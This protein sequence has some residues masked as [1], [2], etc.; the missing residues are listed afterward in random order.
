[1]LQQLQ[2]AAPIGEKAFTH[3]ERYISSEVRYQ[4]K[5]SVSCS[6]LLP[7]AAQ[8]SSL[9]VFS[10]SQGIFAVCH[11]IAKNSEA[12]KQRVTEVNFMIIERELLQMWCPTFE[13]ETFPY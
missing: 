5:L 13:E 1:M 8:N 2:M 10:M 12:S 3:Y 6:I 4:Q 7:Q 11:F 9:H